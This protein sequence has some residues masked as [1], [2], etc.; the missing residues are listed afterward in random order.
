M[1]VAV[2]AAIVLAAGTAYAQQAATLRGTVVERDGGEPVA[3]AIVTVGGELVA[4][5]DDGT[6]VVTLAPGTYTVEVTAEWLVTAKRPIVLKGDGTLRIEVEKRSEVGGETIEVVDIAPTQIGETKVDAK[7]ARAVPGG[8]DAAKVVQALP[9]VARPPAGSAEIV[10]W[11]AAPR[12][13]RVFVDG[14]PVPSL[15]H[16]GGYRAAVGNELVGDIR[17]TPAAFGPDRGRAIGGVIDIGFGDPKDLPHWRAQADVLDATI[18]G[19]EDIG[20]WSFGAALRK[21][22]LDRA[23]DAVADP[24]EL[25]PNAP[26]PRWTDGQV[27]LRGMLTDRITL[28]SWL[29][30][31]LDQLDRTLASDD[32]STQTTQTIDQRWLRAQVTLRRERDDG[33]DS[34]TLWFGRDRTR[35]DLDVGLIPARQ[36]T[37]L[38]V[39]GA[40][41]IQQSRVNDVTTLTLGL[42]VDGEAATL[43]KEGSLTIPAREGD[44]RIF[45]QP[46]GDDVNADRW[47]ATTLDAGGYA[48]VDLRAGRFTGTFGTRVD[49]WALSASR[50]TPRIGTTPGIGSQ[51]IDLTVDPRVAVQARLTESLGVRADA[52]RYHQARAASDTSAVFGTPS[53]GLEEAWHATLGGQWRASPFAIE[54]AGYARW[55]DSLV[56]RDLAVTPLYAQALTQGGTGE[57]LGMQMT[58]RVVGW[59]GFSGWLSYGLS[60]STRKDADTATERYFDR[61]QTHGLIAVGG[62][63]RGPWNVGARVRISTGEPRTDVIGSF[64]D[65]RSGRFQ[66][67]R[68]PHNGVRLPM[69]FAADLR[70][71]RK[72]PL[73]SVRAA[74]YI[75]VQN[76]TG[77]ANAEEIIY[78]ADFTMRSY[79]TGLPL[80]AIAGVRIEQ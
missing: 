8:G 59:R 52:G 77:R 73:A 16:L 2:A 74:V 50:L 80:L 61:D 56:A 23:V 31:S 47:T 24:R 18:A 12:D 51:Q 62:W 13:T 33:T 37:A 58:A 63:Q 70:G 41:A 28:T 17:L 49:A 67:I 10:V 15:Y 72:F 5:G 30:G 26:L 11:G 64:Y 25:A 40:R 45:G 19:S 27:I 14:V 20:R 43:Q 54:I 71:E 7:L 42:D 22:W 4:T 48:A 65:S 6:F 75:E 38:W 69:F 79:L 76:L 60:K 21:S 29:I 34:A 44:L 55:L 3:G 39:A 57:V 36:R 78:S 46:P 53:L 32:P 9:A 1:R 35:D 66:P 68:G